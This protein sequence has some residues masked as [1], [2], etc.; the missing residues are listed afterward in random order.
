MRLLSC[1]V[2]FWFACFELSQGMFCVEGFKGL[3][4]FCSN[5]FGGCGLCQPCVDG[6]LL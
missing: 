5:V 4:L 3:S 1:V 6:G 2:L